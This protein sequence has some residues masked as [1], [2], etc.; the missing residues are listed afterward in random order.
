[1]QYDT[2]GDLITLVIYISTFYGS[3]IL[4]NISNTILW[5]YTIL[6]MFPQYDTMSEFIV[7]IG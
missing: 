3:M 2:I 4:L 5:T 1:M 7:L 6:K